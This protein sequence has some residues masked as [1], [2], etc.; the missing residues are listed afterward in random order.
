MKVWRKLKSKVR[1]G[2]RPSKIL[3][4]HSHVSYIRVIIA[5]RRTVKKCCSLFLFPIKR[6]TALNSLHSNLPPQFSLRTLQ[7]PHVLISLRLRYF[8]VVGIEIT[9]LPHRIYLRHRYHR[10]IE[11]TTNCPATFPINQYS[12]L[13]SRNVEFT[14]RKL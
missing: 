10:S 4:R 11:R 9:F 8:R 5:E 7:H 3:S 1:Q 14:S 6:I 13:F 2:K 12:T